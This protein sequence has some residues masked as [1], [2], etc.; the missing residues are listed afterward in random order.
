M[1]LFKKGDIAHKTYTFRHDIITKLDNVIPKFL[2]PC[3]E[4]GIH[5]TL[6][7]YIKCHI[8]MSQLTPVA[9]SLH[10]LGQLPFTS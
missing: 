10:P 6:H 5:C 9:P 7:N 8:P 2:H 1:I 4:T 3:F